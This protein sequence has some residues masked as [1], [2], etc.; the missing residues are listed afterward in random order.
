[1]VP[2]DSNGISLVPPYSGYCYNCKAYDHGAIT[3]SGLP[4]QVTYLQ[5]TVDVAVLQPHSGRNHYGLG[6]S[7]F[8]RHYLRNHYYFLFLRVLRCFSSPGLLTYSV[9]TLQVAGF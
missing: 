9:T 2:A 5:F 6:S 8:A 4:F 3:L 1:M 7:A